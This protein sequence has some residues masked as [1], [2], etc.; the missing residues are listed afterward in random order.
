[1]GLVAAACFADVGHDV[2]GVDRDQDKLAMLRRGQAP[3]FEPGLEDLMKTA[4]PRLRFTDDLA[5]ATRESDVVFVAVG[6]PELPSGE[7]DMGPTRAAVE[8]VAQA[9]TGPLTV[10]LKSTV[11]IGSWR[12]IGALMRS[13]TQHPIR[14]VS[15]PEF[16][17]EGAAV[18]DFLRPDR[19]VIGVED[20]P[21]GREASSAASLMRRLYEPFVKNGHPILIMD[22]ASAEMSKYAANA[23]LSVKISFINELAR[24]ADKA[25]AD[26]N[27]VRQGFTSDRRINPAFFYPGVG[28]GGSCF[29]KDVK[30]IVQTGKALGVEMSVVAAADL[31]NQRQRDLFFGKIETH[32]AS[33][34]GLKGRH[35]AVWGLAF[36]PRTDD[37]REAPAFD[38]I[39]KLLSS[40][41][42]VA[43]YDPIARETSVRQWHS[44]PLTRSAFE[45][46]R[47]KLSESANEAA[48]N[49]DALALLTEWNE[50][51]TADLKQ[52]K[53]LL[54]QSVVFDGRNVFDPVSARDA[55]YLYYCFGR[56]TLG[57][58]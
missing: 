17:K 37:T 46:G 11:P 8:A 22:N 5:Q 34:G 9:A 16:L 56:E 18:D 55:G 42:T 25:G 57:R 48:S 39:R 35:I 2:I 13:R 52:L 58:R 26:I 54:R 49:A 6:T 23:F 28:F 29:P 41:A 10:V 51:R 45:T 38:I 14:I 44:D 40:G 50:F 31:A 21:E 47:L 12:E 24:L 20:A 27:L 7:A 36:K 33:Q 19:I 30:A 53:G 3:F 4:G 43:A 1:M 15:N 32:F